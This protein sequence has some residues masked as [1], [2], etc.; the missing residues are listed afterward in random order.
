MGKMAV[1]SSSVDEDMTKGKARVK[2]VFCLAV[3]GNEERVFGSV[4]RWVMGNH[5]Q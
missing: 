2:Q 4:E 5:G 3:S 1:P